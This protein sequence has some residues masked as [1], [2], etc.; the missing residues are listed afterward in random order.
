MNILTFDI[1]EWYLEKA[2]HGGREERYDTF[3]QY[4]SQILDF[5]N[6]RSIK[7]T[8]F[9]VGKMAIDFPTVVKKVFNEGHEIGCHSNTHTWLNKLT[10][11][12]VYEDTRVAVD[13]L[14]QCLGI[15]VK[16]YRA[17]AFSIGENNLWTF[18]I[19]AECGI[20]ND[21]SVFPISRDF[22]GFSSFGSQLPTLIS[23]KNHLIKEFPICTSKILG[24]QV[25]FSGGG[26]FRFFPYN[27]INKRLKTE[28]YNICY[29][30]IADLMP[31][32]SKV[33]TKEA[34]EYY[35]KEPGTWYNRHKRFFKENVGKKT[36]LVK[37]KKLIQNNN[38]SSIEETSNQINWDLYPNK[39]INI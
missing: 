19:L 2:F 26:Y 24:K 27:F 3:D 21:A 23:T 37:L 35:F 34:Y 5:L 18:D 25:A 22:G 9:V 32:S 8:F 31:T 30:H 39:I 33:M 20:E 12:E 29:F 11:E 36:A 4:L 38:F 14:E 16:S 13:S 10:K 28:S 15:K 1:E 17:P 6:S 7:A